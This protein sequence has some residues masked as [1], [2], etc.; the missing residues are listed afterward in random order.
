M[1]VIGFIYKILNKFGLYKPEAALCD[2]EI[3]SIHSGDFEAKSQLMG[4]QIWKHNIP[5]LWDETQG[6]GV[7]V[8]ILDTGVQSDHPDLSERIAFLYPDP[9]NDAQGHGTHCAGITAGSNNEIG[10]VGVAPKADLF[11][12]KVLNDQGWGTL[13]D[14]ANGIYKA[15]DM[16]VD[17]ISMSLGAPV[18]DE[19]LHDAVKAAYEAN[20]PVVCAAGNSGDIGMLDYPGRYPET[21]SV[22]AL[23]KDNLRA[24]FSQTGPLLDFMAPGVDIPSTY[25][26]NAYA[27][28]SGTSMAT[29]WV[30]GV[31]ALMIAKHRK[32]GG[33]TPVD[34]VEQIK[35]HLKWTAIDLQNVGKDDK[36]GYG[37]VDVAKAI[38]ELD[39][40][41]IEELPDIIVSDMRAN[42]PGK[43]SK[44]LN[45]E[46]IAFKNIGSEPADMTGFILKDRAGWTYVFP[47]FVLQPNATVRV[48]TGI[49]EDREDS[50]FWG[51]RRP[52]W[53]N[54]GDSCTLTTADGEL[55]TEYAYGDA[56]K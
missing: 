23:D 16:G 7:K 39:P 22:G 25:I 47:E 37:L 17:V 27:Y 55:V 24:A 14:V 46:W 6:E 50:L 30:A 45:R 41:I 28:L 49:G 8:A 2:Y 5:D 10:F 44:H 38:A 32:V 20:I 18:S 19:M 31:I 42:P 4:Y 51:M 56:V 53:N 11:I 40:E 33:S 29:P 54:K 52:I 43:D 35:E 36:T 34:T 15:I 9:A 26:T 12:I 13:E 3:I 21:I 48:R 1:S